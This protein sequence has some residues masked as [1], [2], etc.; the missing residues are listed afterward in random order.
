MNGARCRRL[1]ELPG[2][3]YYPNLVP[4]WLSATARMISVTAASVALVGIAVAVCWMCVGTLGQQPCRPRRTPHQLCAPSSGNQLGA[5]PLP[6][7]H[8]HGGPTR[9]AKIKLEF[10]S[11]FR[12]GRDLSG[13]LAKQAGILAEAR[14]DRVQTPPGWL[15]ER[16]C[17]RQPKH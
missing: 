2:V 8:A 17:E 1:A 10:V 16:E 14:R 15:G 11:N 7:C 5:P 6:Q 3:T 9:I 13:W 4:G 12:P